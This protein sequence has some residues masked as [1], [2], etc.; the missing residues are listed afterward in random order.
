M[1]RRNFSAKIASILGL[2]AVSGKTT[3]NVLSPDEIVAAWEKPSQKSL[4]EQQ[5]SELPPNPAGE[6]TAGQ[7]KEDMLMASG[8]NCSGNN[9]SGNNCS[10]NN[11]SGNNCSAGNYCGSS[12][13]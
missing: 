7:H 1:K 9:C 13:A 4:S 3:A 12:S 2:V 8:N 10:G 5:W 6:I 11:C